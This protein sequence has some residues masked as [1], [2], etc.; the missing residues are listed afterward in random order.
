[1]AHA[2]C[3]VECRLN[4]DDRINGRYDFYGGPTL[5]NVDASHDDIIKKVNE[6]RR[7][8][9]REPKVFRVISD[10]KD[11]DGNRKVIVSTRDVEDPPGIDALSLRFARACMTH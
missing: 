6:E 11:A 2:L 5:Q 3:F 7:Q 4:Y 9:E 8:L 10:N 1:M